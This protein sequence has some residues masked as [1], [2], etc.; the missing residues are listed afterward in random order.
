MQYNYSGQVAGQRATT[1]ASSS[2]TGAAMASASATGTTTPS[3][4]AAPAHALIGTLLWLR[5]VLQ[6][7]SVVTQG[8]LKLTLLPLLSPIALV[9]GFKSSIS[10]SVAGTRILRTAPVAGLATFR[11]RTS[12]ARAGRY[13]RAAADRTFDDPLA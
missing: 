1:A 10:V 9:P 4:A 12:G 3:A 2:S 7:L 5:K 11:A 8:E 13:S 6:R